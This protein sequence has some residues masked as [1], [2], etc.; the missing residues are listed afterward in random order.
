MVVHCKDGKGRTGLF[1]CCLLLHLRVCNTAEEAL[2]FGSRRTE[3]GKGD[4]P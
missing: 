2:V 1:V 4:H 3:D